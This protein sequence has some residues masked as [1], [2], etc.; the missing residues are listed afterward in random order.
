MAAKFH[1]SMT[2]G[3]AK[4]RIEI[5]PEGGQSA[6][7]E[8]EASE[9]DDVLHGL[10]GIRQQLSEPIPEQLDPRP[11][12]NGTANPNWK[13]S[14]HPEGRGLIFRHPGFGWLGFIVRQDRADEIAELLVKG[15]GIFS[16]PASPASKWTLSRI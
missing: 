9:L 16:P 5:L 4:A 10:A 15:D 8:L 3:N 2:P 14:P 6:W 12:I 1:L 11:R 7:V 13:V